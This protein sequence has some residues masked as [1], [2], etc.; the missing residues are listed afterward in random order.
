M[1]KQSPDRPEVGEL[2]PIIAARHPDGRPWSITDHRGR[3]L[4]MIFHRHI[5]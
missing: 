1:A 3:T 5:H 2:A 4:V